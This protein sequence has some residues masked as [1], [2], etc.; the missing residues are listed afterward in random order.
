[1]LEKK[2]YTQKGLRDHILFAPDTY[3]GGFEQLIEEK[4]PVLYENKIKYL[5]TTYIP[6]VY[7]IFDE[8]MVNSRDA[9]I[10]MYH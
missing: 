9:W 2:K 1:M 5:N 3:V 4:I 7:K 6:A 8:I 10:I